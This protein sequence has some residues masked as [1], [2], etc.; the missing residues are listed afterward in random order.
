MSAAAKGSD[1]GDGSLGAF[2]GVCVA[3]VVATAIGTALH[4]AYRRRQAKQGSADLTPQ[5]A[6]SR[7]VRTGDASTRRPTARSE[8]MC[9]AS[10]TTEPDGAVFNS[11]F[12]SAEAD[13]Y[14]RPN[15]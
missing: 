2:I 4:Y 7:D 13:T 11:A 8:S 12:D 10:A 1:T 3:L 6:R 15:F 14:A 9:G 5:P